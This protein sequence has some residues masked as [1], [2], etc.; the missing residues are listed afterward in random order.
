MTSPCSG[1]AVSLTVISI[2]IGPMAQAAPGGALPP[3]ATAALN[4]P[5]PK[6]LPPTSLASPGATGYG[7][8]RSSWLSAASCR[9]PGFIDSSLAD[10]LFA[11]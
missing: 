9:A 1:T 2:V 7:K 3:E 5:V 11:S 6:G 4:G 8:A 10:K